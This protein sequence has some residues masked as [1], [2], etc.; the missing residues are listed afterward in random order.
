MVEWGKSLKPGELQFFYL[1]D[2]DTA[3]LS[4]EV[5]RQDRGEVSRNG[6]LCPVQDASHDTTPT[7][8]TIAITPLIYAFPFAPGPGRGSSQIIRL[9]RISYLIR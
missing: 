4:W 3:I 7:P 5:S 9:I 2:E 1:K 8:S 6:K